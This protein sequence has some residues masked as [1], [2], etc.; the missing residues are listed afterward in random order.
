MMT[1]RA[2]DKLAVQEAATVVAREQAV[3]AMPDA[4][5]DPEHCRVILE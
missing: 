3:A 1:F 5:T 4:Y 2:L